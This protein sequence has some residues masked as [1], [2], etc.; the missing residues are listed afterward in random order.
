MRSDF[1]EIVQR[2]VAISS[3][4]PSAVRGQGK[5]VQGACH[6]HLSSLRLERIPATG[7]KAY[8]AW[9]DRQTEK[10]LDALSSVLPPANRP[11]GTARKAL[12]LFMR[13]ALH[14]KYLAREYG[15]DKL[16]SWLE[17]PLD[18]VVAK[19]LRLPSDRGRLPVWPGLKHLQPAVSV[20]YQAK[21]KEVAVRM[22][23][24]RVHLD[25][26]LWLANR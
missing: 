14:D 10:L 11:W 23:I 7:G 12:N 1:V 4:G 26:Y 20:L 21:A 22:G 24:A 5:G 15:L 17:I 16:E 18:R 6:E 25:M 9:L 2:M 13:D 3:V 8:E 19:G